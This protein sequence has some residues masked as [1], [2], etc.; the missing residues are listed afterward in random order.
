MLVHACNFFLLLLS[1]LSWD[2]LDYIRPSLINKASS[3]KTL[4]CKGLQNQFNE[5]VQSCTHLTIYWLTHSKR[6]MIK[7]SQNHPTKPGL[8]TVPLELLGIKE[9]VCPALLRAGMSAL[10]LLLTLTLAT[11]LEQGSAT[12]DRAR[13][14]LLMHPI[15]DTRISVFRTSDFVR[16]A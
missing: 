4:N 5:S 13:S 10:T 2:F 16:N 11:T 6:P 9:A 15:I 14:V 12:P 1:F 7:L 3:I 8:L